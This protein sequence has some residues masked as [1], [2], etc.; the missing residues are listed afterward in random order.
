M[1][2]LLH[3]AALTAA[4]GARRPPVVDVVCGYLPALIAASSSL[5]R[6]SSVAMDSLASP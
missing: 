1:D 2:L 5:S 4:T 3:V 6:V